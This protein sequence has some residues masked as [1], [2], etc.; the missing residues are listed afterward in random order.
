M[1]SRTRASVRT[2]TMCVHANMCTCTWAGTRS[3]ARRQN[4]R[5]HRSWRMTYDCIRRSCWQRRRGRGGGG[6]ERIEVIQGMEMFGWRIGYDQADHDRV[7]ELRGG[8]RLSSAKPRNVL[9]TTTIARDRGRMRPSPLSAP[10]LGARY[11]G[12]RFPGSRW[13]MIESR[14]IFG[15]QRGTVARTR[16]LR[17][18]RIIQ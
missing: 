9:A 1:R 13:V 16:V 4:G 8:E 10:P 5:R 11:Y 6:E 18:G 12:A 15:P 17:I 14:Q 2:A 3:S 7:Q